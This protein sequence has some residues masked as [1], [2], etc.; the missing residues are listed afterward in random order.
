[1]LQDA[2]SDPTEPLK[3]LHLGSFFTSMVGA[4][5]SRPLITLAAQRSTIGPSDLGGAQPF[6]RPYSKRRP[7]LRRYSEYGNTSRS[8]QVFRMFSSSSECSCR[9]PLPLTLGNDC[10]PAGEPAQVQDRLGGTMTCLY[11]CLAALFRTFC[12]LSTSHLIFLSSSNTPQRGA[13]GLPLVAVPFL[14]VVSLCC[15]LLTCL[16]SLYF[17]GSRRWI[18]RLDAVPTIEQRWIIK[19]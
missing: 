4:A 3:L 13:A 8:T 19:E 6:H 11:Y 16:F 5:H 18:Y 9:S 17:F 15:T 7:C 12:V 2:K 10:S 1:L 14:Y